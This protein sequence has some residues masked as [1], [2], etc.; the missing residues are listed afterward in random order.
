MFVGKVIVILLVMTEKAADVLLDELH[1]GQKHLK[2]LQGQVKA[3]KAEIE[4]RKH[5]LDSP[6]GRDAKRRRL[7]EQAAEQRQQWVKWFQARVVD[8]VER[9]EEVTESKG[10]SLIRD[11]IAQLEKA[12]EIVDMSTYCDEPEELVYTHVPSG[13]VVTWTSSVDIVSSHETKCV[14]ARAGYERNPFGGDCNCKHEQIDEVSQ[15]DLENVQ[16]WAK[17]GIAAGR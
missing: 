7:N 6:A 13:R 9:D 3:L 10:E 12:G 14:T 15:V 1:E 16:D 5:K 11:A 8:F 4:R 17:I 2:K